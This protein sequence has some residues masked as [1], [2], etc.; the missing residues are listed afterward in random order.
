[1][2]RISLV[3]VV[4]EPLRAASG[5][6]QDQDAAVSEGEFFGLPGG[7]YSFATSFAEAMAVKKATGGQ[8][9]QRSEAYPGTTA[10]KITQPQRGCVRS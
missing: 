3:A 5:I 1:M 4:F 9:A 8:V 10:P 7:A 2:P 6:F